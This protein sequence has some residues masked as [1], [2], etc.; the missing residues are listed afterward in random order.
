MEDDLQKQWK[1]TSPQKNG[2]R[3]QTNIMEDNLKNINKWKTA[4]KKR[5]K[6]ED[7]LKKSFKSFLG[8]S[9]IKGQTFPGVGS[10]V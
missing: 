10:A 1:T 4:A 5:E 7:D 2:R 3:P 6:M 8:S 9:Q